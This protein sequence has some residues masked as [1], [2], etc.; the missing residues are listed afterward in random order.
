MVPGGLMRSGRCPKCEAT[1]VY[2]TPGQILEGVGFG[3]G[4]P[5]VG[6]FRDLGIVSYVCAACGFLELYVP[7]AYRRE[8]VRETWTHVEPQ[9]P[10]PP[11]D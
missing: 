2:T 10:V 7:Q 6:V 1:E 11:P 3:V 4:T 8:K 5:P 9:T